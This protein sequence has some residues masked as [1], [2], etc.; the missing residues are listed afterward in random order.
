MLGKR[1]FVADLDLFPLSLK[2]SALAH[3]QDYI[4]KAHRNKGSVAVGQLKEPPH[5]QATI[6]RVESHKNKEM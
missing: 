1:K 3:F 5:C 4:N 2:K 6:Q